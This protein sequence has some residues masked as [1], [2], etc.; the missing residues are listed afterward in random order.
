M[1]QKFLRP[2]VQFLTLL[3]T[4][5]IILPWLGCGSETTTLNG[6]LRNGSLPIHSATVSLYRTGTGQGPKLIA[7]TQSD[8]AGAFTLS[9]DPPTSDQEI[10][11]ITAGGTGT[12]P[13]IA[14]QVISN[15]NILFAT[16][17]GN[18]AFPSQV[19][20]NERSTV[21]TAFVMAQFI[22][23]TS[24]D[25]STPGL[26]NAA[27]IFRNL[28][29]LETGEVANFLGTPPNGNATSTLARFNSLANLLA[30]CVN[31]AS[32]C[33]NLFTLATSP[34]GDVPTNTFQAA[35][36]IARNPWQ[37]V[38]ELLNLSLQD[39]TYAPALPGD[40]DLQAWTLVLVYQGNGMQFDGPGNIAFDADGNAWINNNYIF[41]EGV[42]DPD[43]EV[44]GSDQVFKLAPTG[45]NIDGSPFTGGGLYGAGFGITLDPNGDVW[46]SNFGFQG[47]NCPNDLV[48]LAQTVSKF[49][50]D[51]TPLSPDSAGNQVGQDHGGFPGAGNTM[52]RPQG[53]VSDQDGNIWV[54]NCGNNSVTQFP[55]GDP[56]LAF[57]VAP[58]DP[59]G[60]ALIDHPFTLAIDLDGNAWLSSNLNDTIIEF[61]SVGNVVFTLQD[62]EA[63]N[64]GIK[65]PMGLASDRQG[66]IWVANAGLPAPP[67]I[68]GDTT[69]FE[70]IELTMQPGFSNDNASVSMVS[71]DGSALGPF[72]GGGLT[73]PWGI[74]VDG[75][76]NIWVANFDG[77]RLSHLCGGRPE[78]CPPGASTGDAISPDGGYNSNALDRNT[79]VQ[80]DPSGNVW[81]ANNWLPIPIQ[82]NPGARSV[83][84]FIGLATP[85]KTPL[86]GPPNI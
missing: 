23:G 56:D 32:N 15:D 2:L 50:P 26:Q 34:Q 13:A 44:C 73:W 6:F 1:H 43:G 16:V 7:Q 86:I 24:I 37:N 66:N 72:S 31:E 8:E 83:A 33:P 40:D 28:V 55:G 22:N 29:N 21:A 65:F 35:H 61:D 11:Y 3:L 80:I 75:A 62:T 17:L 39:S 38:S 9:F 79:G 53:I 46:V 4:S 51:G 82:T 84:V 76:D 14:T 70:S 57:A 12:D 36:H 69:L 68:T 71:P 20:L 64:A 19:V 52:L 59:M 48:E 45:E 18:S 78:T 60:E 5:L 54:A 41:K 47:S 30:L 49:A 27:K 77:M 42:L 85:V 25:G 58:T 74:A 10:L 63:S 81:L 67:C